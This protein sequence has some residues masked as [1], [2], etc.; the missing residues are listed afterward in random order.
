MNGKREILLIV[1]ASLMFCSF[2]GTVSADNIAEWSEDTRLTSAP[3]DSYSPAIAVDTNNNVHITWYDY[4]DGNNEIYY[5]KLDNNGNTLVDDTRLTSVSS[6]YSS[7]QAIAVDTNNYVHITWHDNRD[8]NDEI[9]Y[10]KLDNNGNT[11]VDD[12]RLTYDYPS[13]SASQVI[14]V[15]TNNNVHI[16]W[17]DWRHANPEIYYTKLDN[18]GNTLIDD[19]RITT[20]SY[21]SE[22]PAIAVDTNNNVH[23]TWYHYARDG[24][25]IYYTKLDNNGNT[26]VDDTRL[27]PAY[28][29]SKNP[30]IAVDTNN[31]VHI[32]W[33]DSRDGND[34]IYYK[35]SIAST[36]T[37]PV[38][39]LDTGEDFATIQAAIDD[40]DTLDGHTITVDAGTYTENVD[41]SKSLTIKSY[42]GN[43]ADTIVQAQNPD[44]HV[45]EVT[46]DHVNVRGFTIKG[47]TG[48]GKA[49]IYLNSDYCNVSDNTALN[50][51]YGIYLEDSSNN[52][53][54]NN[55][56][57][58][59][60][61][62]GISLASSSNNKVTGNTANSN[63]NCG[64]Y[65]DSSSSN[66]IYNNYFNN[67]RNAY[68]DGT[69]IWNITKTAGTNIIGGSWLGG[70]YWSDYFG[71]DTSG[72]GLGDTFT[73]YNS[74]G[75]ITCGGDWLP[76]V[77]T[78][79]EPFTQIPVGVTSNISLTDTED[80][81]AYLP[82][83]YD[84]IDISDA[85]VLNVNVTDDTPGNPADDAY[86]DITINIGSMNIRTCKVFKSGLGF[87][88]EV[89]DV[90]TL[91]T[92]DGDPAFSRDFINNTVTVRLYMGDPLLGVLPPAE[93]PWDI[94]EDGI[95]NY[96]DAAYIGIHYGETTTEPYPRYDIN[97]DGVVNYLDAAYIGIHYGEVT[98]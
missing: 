66:F 25:E 39:N 98:S 30:A 8:G 91:L 7:G 42:S 31:N 74:S 94:N 51:Y 14:A 21:F 86:T 22:C 27:T 43:P 4:R 77:K 81:T 64:I 44:D 48:S 69:N 93:S 87:L 26:L 12:T 47:A 80:I 24:Y 2:V 23:I 11:L 71:D 59:N 89:A 29:W 9:Y 73:P 1:I 72:D 18:N 83:E 75:N 79:E 19:T 40:S 62:E 49:G 65:L 85:V 36:P 34:E 82:P 28:S 63:T 5:T 57:N 53:L 60:N 67:T 90:A 38:H 61:D 95:I 56:A 35:H 96:L 92:V 6:A 58:S 37:L 15:D 50:N 78:E 17:E 10:T 97:K 76:L 16:T 20:D 68:D 55:N 41:V 13:T 52:T 70:N 84:G 32:T 46:V 45:F 88:P 33:S 3:S 54:T